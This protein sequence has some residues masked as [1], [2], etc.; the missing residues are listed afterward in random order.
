MPLAE[1][2]GDGLGRVFEGV[3]DLPDRHR[4][5]LKLG[6]L[7]SKAPAGSASPPPLRATPG[8]R[9]GVSISV[10]SLSF[11]LLVTLGRDRPHANPPALS[12]AGLTPRK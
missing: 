7:L 12:F 1:K 5:A 8:Y 11:P 4:M 2:G 9:A 10:L 6:G 3:V